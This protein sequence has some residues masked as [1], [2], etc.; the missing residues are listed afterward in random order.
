MPTE[1]ESLEY[2]LIGLPGPAGVTIFNGP[3][4]EKRDPGQSR[5]QTTMRA[6]PPGH[7]F[8]SM[9][10]CNAITRQLPASSKSRD[11]CR[12]QCSKTREPKKKTDSAL[13][14]DVAG[15]PAYLRVIKVNTRGGYCEVHNRCTCPD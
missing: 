4:S 9:T 7:H 2:R 12:I 3:D 11:E 5:Q 13:G 1:M 6:D 15:L 10:S 8:G 14:R